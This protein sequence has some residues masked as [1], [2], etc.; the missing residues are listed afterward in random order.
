MS[1]RIE[2]IDTITNETVSWDDAQ[3]SVRHE[4]ASCNLT[5]CGGTTYDRESATAYSWW[6]IEDKAG[7]A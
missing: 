5:V 6:R 2:I 7:G 1:Q 4:I 3:E